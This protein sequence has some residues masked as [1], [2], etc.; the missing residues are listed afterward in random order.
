MKKLYLIPALAAFLA[1]AGL[2]HAAS[3]SDLV[4]GFKDSSLTTN[5]E[6]DLGSI[7]SYANATSSFTVGNFGSLLNAYD[8]GFASSATLLWGVGGT[9]GNLNAGP[10]G[11][12]AKTQW[13]TQT[14]GSATGTL[15]EQNTIAP[16]AVSSSGSG[17]AATNAGKIYTGFNSGTSVG[18][19]AIT[20]ATSSGNSFNAAVGP[21]NTFGVYGTINKF[22]SHTGTLA[23]AD[24]YEMAPATAGQFLGTFAL[25]SS[26]ILTFNVI[27]AAIPEPSTYAAILGVAVLGFAMLRRKQAIV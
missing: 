13:I 26:G 19:N 6:I 22:F 18:P 7:S 11:E 8:P 4:L 2:S 15:G 17:T 25:D 16:T 9:D 20:I 3:V 21:S 1:T 14:W 23:A 12:L 27:S 24:L 10:D 5:L